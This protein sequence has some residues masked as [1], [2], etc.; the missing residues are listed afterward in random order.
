MT[1]K[2]AALLSLVVVFAVLAGGARAD[3][4]TIVPTPL[5]TPLAPDATA[6]LAPL[7]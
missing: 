3:T 6:T 4:F 5:V 2:R 1:V 7:P